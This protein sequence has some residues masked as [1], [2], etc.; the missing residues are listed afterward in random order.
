[1]L[2]HLPKNII[3]IL[4]IYKRYAFIF[5]Q[6]LLL[7]KSCTID[8]LSQPCIQTFINNNLKNISNM[9]VVNCLI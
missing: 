2:I 9:F 6:M 8:D 4:H 5:I 7:F 3:Y 1:M